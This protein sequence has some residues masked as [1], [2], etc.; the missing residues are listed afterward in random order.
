MSLRSGMPGISAFGTLACLTGEVPRVPGGQRIGRG[1]VGD[2]AEHD[3]DG[4]DGGGVVGRGTAQLLQGKE[5]DTTEA[6]P[7]GPNQPTRAIVARSS[8]ARQGDRDWR[9]RITV[10]LRTAYSTI[11][12]V[13]TST[14]VRLRL[15]R[16]PANQQR[17]QGAG[18]LDERH[19]G[20]AAP[21]TCGA[22]REPADEPAEHSGG[23]SASLA[24]MARREGKTKDPS[25]PDR[26][27]H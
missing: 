3:G 23:Q 6:R 7:R 11:C 21:A 8:P 22:E 10:R 24:I 9:I 16:R 12:Q 2:D 1:A 13:R 5:A 26:R 19:Q 17:H 15:R 4:D 27:S 18:F 25:R 14:A 20:L